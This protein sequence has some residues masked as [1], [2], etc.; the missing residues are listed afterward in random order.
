M[1]FNLLFKISLNLGHFFFDKKCSNLKLNINS[2]P[3]FIKIKKNN[4]NLQFILR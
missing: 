1:F 4:H 3:N 2:K